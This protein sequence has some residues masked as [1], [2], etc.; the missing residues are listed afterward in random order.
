MIL[1]PRPGRSWRRFFGGAFPCLVLCGCPAWGSPF[2]PLLL[3]YGGS[4]GDVIYGYGGDDVLIGTDSL[5]GGSGRDRINGGTGRDD[6]DAGPDST[7]TAC[8]L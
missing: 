1:R 7:L 2:S 4:G 8:E 6:C 5:G 3:I